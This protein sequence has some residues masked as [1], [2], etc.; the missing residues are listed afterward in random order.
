MNAPTSFGLAFFLRVSVPGLIFLLLATPLLPTSIITDLSTSGLTTLLGLAGISGLVIFLLDTF[1]YDVFEGRALWP[2]WL[3]SRLTAGW[4][5]R[6]DVK[7][8]KILQI[9]SN[10]QQAKQILGDNAD[11]VI[12]LERELGLMYDNVMDFPYLEDGKPHAIWPTR[13]GNVMASYEYY[14]QT[15]Y[16][17]DSA[18]YWYRLWLLLPD[19]T[20]KE[21]DSFWALGQVW[22]YASAVAIASILVYG[23]LA[24][25]AVLAKGLSML[26][27]HVGPGSLHDVLAF[28]GIPRTSQRIALFIGTQ[29]AWDWGVFVFLLGMTAV[30]SLLWAFAYQQALVQ[31]RVSGEFFKSLFDM[32]RE[33]IEV[34]KFKPG[35]EGDWKDAANYLRFFR[36]G[37]VLRRRRKTSS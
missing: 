22:L 24:S 6:L 9:E 33:E 11:D 23:A 26:S 14:P 2:T 8:T 34:Q 18:F 35:A 27:D 4:Q 31:H 20:R 30:A 32:Y 7:W 5:K 19:E 13:F 3:R 1:F 12:R 28:L 29:C 37:S 15:R 36:G 25:W 17:M 10:L 16:G 21:Y